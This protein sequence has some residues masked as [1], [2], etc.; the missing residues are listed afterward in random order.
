MRFGRRLRAQIR[1]WSYILEE[2]SSFMTDGSRRGVGG[3]EFGCRERKW[4]LLVS[5]S[6]HLLIRGNKRDYRL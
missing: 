6:V 5:P 1:H 2:P 3:H 4:R